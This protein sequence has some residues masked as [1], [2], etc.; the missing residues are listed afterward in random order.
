MFLVLDQPV[1]SIVS[2]NGAKT[3]KT[4]LNPVAVQIEVIRRHRGSGLAEP[5]RVS[6]YK[7][8]PPRRGIAPRA[9]V[10]EAD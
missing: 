6:V 5:A 8:G 4:L 2:F 10:S 1:N 9:P 7:D 3:R